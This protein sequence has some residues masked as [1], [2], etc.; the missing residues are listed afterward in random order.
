MP[1]PTKTPKSPG[2]HA[3]P[4]KAVTKSSRDAPDAVDNKILVN[5]LKSFDK[6]EKK[7]DL[8]VFATLQGYTNVRSASNTFHKLRK[9]YGLN[10]EGFMIRT[11]VSPTKATKVAKS[12][13]KTRVTKK[14][15]EVSSGKV[16]RSSDA[17]DLSSDGSE[18]SSL[19]EEKVL[20]NEPVGEDHGNEDALVESPVKKFDDEEIPAKQVLAAMNLYVQGE[21]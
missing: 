6:E 20:A 16:N 13:G 14:T 9:T 15:K 11:K 17:I 5:I 1:S 8:N 3:T 7:I 2:K 10:V 4:V 21:L 12:T 19:D 18:L